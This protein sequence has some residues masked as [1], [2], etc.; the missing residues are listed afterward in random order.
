MTRA[1]LLPRHLHPGAWW[2]WA[3]G[4]ATAA[5]RTT[6][7]LLLL[8]LAAVAGYVVMARRT[9]AP[10]ARSY[11]AF[12]KL[13]LIVLAIRVVLQALF[14]SDLPGRTLVTLPSV[15]LP[16][17]AAGVRIGGRIT[18]EGLASAVYDGLRLAVLLCCVG[19]A[20][21]L[22]SPVRLLRS[23]PAALYEV[24]VA[25]TVALSFAPQ[26]V[27]A[28]SRIRAARRLRGRADRGLAGLRG[29]AMPVLEDALE[30]SV[31]LAA[32]MDSRGYGRR[33][34]VP[35]AR[36]RATVA[37]TLAGLAAVSVGVYGVLDAASPT[38]L[39]LPTLVVGVALATAGLVAG[40][41]RTPRSRY[42]PDPWALPEWCVAVAGL[43]T[44]VGVVGAAATGVA[45][46]EPS[47]MPLETPGLPL[48]PVLAILCGLAPAWL[49][50]APPQ[51]RL[52]AG[53]SSRSVP[54]GAP[55]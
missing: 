18:L 47:T 49:S 55:A 24:G 52:V 16:E 8:L 44:A 45:S 7:P 12:L 54:V 42:R 25:V 21:A 11:G 1:W 36:R 6:N 13:G 15:P 27:V 3:L 33:V 39:G 46:M 53:R 34:S 28:V 30:R 40:G 41:S 38:M 23:L 51:P 2:V 22:A 20:N 4:L 32:A 9:D 35:T 10:W 19:A 31:A 29:L 26:A 17:W 50:P 5:T 48:V 37:L 43:V 14:G